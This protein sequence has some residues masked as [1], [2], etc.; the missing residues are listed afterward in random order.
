MHIPNSLLKIGQLPRM[1]RALFSQQG[2][3]GKESF[4]LLFLMPNEAFNT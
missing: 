2:A 1:E 4:T 3:G